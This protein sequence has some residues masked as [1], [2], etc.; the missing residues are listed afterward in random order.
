MTGCV[1]CIRTFTPPRNLKREMSTAFGVF[2]SEVVEDV[3]VLFSA[4]IAWRID[5][6]ERVFHPAEV[7]ERLPDGRLRYRVKTGSK[8]EVLAWVKSF[9]GD[10]ELVAPKD[11]RSDVRRQARVLLAR[12][13]A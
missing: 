10:A 5:D 6:V 2:V 7:K 11:W 4:E 8:D 1:P 12:H 9:G 3:E 13:G